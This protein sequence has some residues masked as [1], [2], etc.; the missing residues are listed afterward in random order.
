MH[1]ASSGLHSRLGA[2]R[3]PLLYT[4]A[5]HLWGWFAARGDRRIRLLQ[6]SATACR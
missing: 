3:G 4:T 6:A 2:R 5:R 1:S